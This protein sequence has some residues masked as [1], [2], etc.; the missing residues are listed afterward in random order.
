MKIYIP[1]DDNPPWVIESCFALA[2]STTSLMWQSEVAYLDDVPGDKISQPRSNDMFNKIKCCVAEERPQTS[3][4]SLDTVWRR[5]QGVIQRWRSCAIMHAE[6][7][8]GEQRGRR[9]GLP[10][11]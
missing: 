8:G 5:S 3:R 9:T 11:G 6:G 2:L 1:L 7:N 4:S 10:G